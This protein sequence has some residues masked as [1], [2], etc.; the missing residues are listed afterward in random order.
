MDTNIGSGRLVYAGIA[1][2]GAILATS[3]IQA[4][5]FRQS[6]K[7]A[8]RLGGAKNWRPRPEQVPNGFRVTGSC[9]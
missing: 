7:G 9:G 3:G 8:F 6:L 5:A 4:S 2:R 1:K